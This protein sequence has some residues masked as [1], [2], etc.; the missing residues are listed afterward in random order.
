MT[1]YLQSHSHSARASAGGVSDDSVDGRGRRGGGAAPSSGR[2]T[3]MR[4]YTT[5][6]TIHRNGGPPTSV[7]LPASYDAWRFPLT[8]FVVRRTQRAT[9]SA[10]VRRSALCGASLRHMARALCDGRRRR[11]TAGAVRRR[12]ASCDACAVQ[13]AQ[14]PCVARHCAACVG[15]RRRA[16]PHVVSRRRA[17]FHAVRRGVVRRRRR[18]VRRRPPHDARRRRTTPAPH[19]DSKRHTT[20]SKSAYEGRRTAPTVVRRRQSY[21]R[22]GSTVPMVQRI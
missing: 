19:G 6:T 22:R 7:A 21:L 11:T 20:L 17:A 5:G 15:D 18:V 10:A 9:K 3:C 8:R 4:A 1:T 2:R 12:R 16:A 14:A 13:R